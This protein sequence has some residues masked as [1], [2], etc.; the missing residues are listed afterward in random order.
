MKYFLKHNSETQVA[1]RYNGTMYY[2]PPGVKT[3]VAS[4]EMAE[5][6]KL[7][8][9]NLGKTSFEIIEEDEETTT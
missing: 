9:G 6:I 3:E 5:A 8:H 7:D 4:K 1:E 2:F